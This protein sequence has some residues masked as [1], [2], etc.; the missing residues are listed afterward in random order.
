V[1][2]LQEALHFVIIFYSYLAKLRKV[3]AKFRKECF[4][5]VSFGNIW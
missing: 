3:P 1:N 5:H 4:L 2:F